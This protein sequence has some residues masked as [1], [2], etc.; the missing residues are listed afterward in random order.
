MWSGSTLED[1]PLAGNVLS[2]DSDADGDT[3]TATVVGLPLGTLLARI[4]FPARGMLVL[5]FRAGM[6]F[7]TGCEAR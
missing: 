2:N 3:L 5:A 1:T 6:A 4:S 7:P